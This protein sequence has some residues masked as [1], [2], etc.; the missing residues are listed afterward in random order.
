MLSAARV[1]AFTHP[2]SSFGSLSL[3]VQKGS[4]ESKPKS[5]VLTY[6]DDEQ[7]VLKVKVAE[8]PDVKSKKEFTIPINSAVWTSLKRALANIQTG[9]TDM[10]Q[11]LEYDDSLFA[12]TTEA[13]QDV[14]KHGVDLVNNLGSSTIRTAADDI[15]LALN[16]IEQEGLPEAAKSAINQTRW[17][18][19]AMPKPELIT[20][21]GKSGFKLD[22]SF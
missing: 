12:D 13:V 18:G 8:G 19:L 10:G 21:K 3:T 14:V 5:A 17:K 16:S 2:S 22:V 9:G 11:Q 15:A 20:Q 6:V 4:S 1:N 7:Y